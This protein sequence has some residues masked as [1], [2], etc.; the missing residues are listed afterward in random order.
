M[1]QKKNR[2]DKRLHNHSE[3]NLTA[4]N[5]LLKALLKLHGFRPESFTMP[6]LKLNNLA[7]LS[8]NDVKFISVNR[9]KLDLSN[10]KNLWYRKFSICRD[11]A[12]FYEHKKMT[13][14]IQLCLTKSLPGLRFRLASQSHPLLPSCLILYGDSP[15]P[16]THPSPHPSHIF[17]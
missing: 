16:A 11:T 2:L 6:Y 13:L 1:V 9:Q 15:F 4:S 17:F 12:R 5:F 8:A 7:E 14:V 3:W 10:Y